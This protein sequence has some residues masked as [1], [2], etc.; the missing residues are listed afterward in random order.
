MKSTDKGSAKNFLPTETQNLLYTYFDA[1]SN[2]Y[3]IIPLYR[4]LRIIQKQN[5][6][7]GLTEEQFLMFI[8]QVE[9]EHHFY[10]II[11]E[12]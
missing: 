5:P 8:E 1:F 11:S 9:N 3:G 10:A 6:E 2:L 12:D 4:A 7:L